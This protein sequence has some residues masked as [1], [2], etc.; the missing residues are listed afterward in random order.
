M[1]KYFM[2]TN[3]GSIIKELRANKNISAYR[4]AK[5]FGLNRSVVH[6]IES[7]RVNPSVPTFIRLLDF[8]GYDLIIVERESKTEHKIEII[9]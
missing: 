5:K 1:P 2:P 9:D 6:A 3:I 7:M 8:F 4:L